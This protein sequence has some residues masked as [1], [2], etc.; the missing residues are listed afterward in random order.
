MNVWNE[1]KT[2]MTDRGKQAITGRMPVRID[3]NTV[4]FIR[5]EDNRDE[6]VKNF[7]EALKM[8]RAIW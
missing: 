6:K 3:S 8:G 5:P 7:N 4:I 2:I 1:N